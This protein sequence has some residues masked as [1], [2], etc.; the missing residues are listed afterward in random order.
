LPFVAVL[1]VQGSK[2]IRRVEGP[3]RRVY[4]F[5]IGQF[6]LEINDFII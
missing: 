6:D 3:A 5:E 2:D 4:P 1:C